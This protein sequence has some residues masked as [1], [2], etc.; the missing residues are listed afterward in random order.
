MGI[1]NLNSPNTLVLN[2]DISGGILKKSYGI[3]TDSFITISR[4]MINANGNNQSNSES[5]G[6]YIENTS[7]DIFN[8][9]IIGGL[10]KEAYG[11]RMD[12]DS[13]PNII[14]NS[15]KIDKGGDSDESKYGIYINSNNGYEPA[16]INNIIA[17]QDAS[18]NYHGIYEG[19]INASP[20]EVR[21]NNIIPVE[22]HITINLYYDNKI[23]PED[24]T[25]ISTLNSTIEN[26]SDNIN[27]FTELDGEL[28]VFNYPV[29][30]N[31]ATGGLDKSSF[32]T[33]DKDGYNRT[34]PWSIGAYEYE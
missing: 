11:I 4:N 3:K 20:S 15:I 12:G 23:L 32:F 13:S 22:D 8:N 17:L 1:L 7:T 18:V 34:I 9:A 14:N 19:S 30:T 10:A 21:N 16:I 31:I 29:D 5:Y 26:S 6:I 27:I 33:K 28:R 2:N 25:D 24:I